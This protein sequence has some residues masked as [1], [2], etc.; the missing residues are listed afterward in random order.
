MQSNDARGHSFLVPRQ[1]GG[2]G[3][4]GGGGGDAAGPLNP[5]L[6][7]IQA[8]G[9]YNDRHAPLRDIKKGDNWFYRGR[10]GYDQATGLGVPDVANLLDSFED[11]EQ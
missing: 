7:F 5:A 11:L 9:G 10:P 8:T 2:G 3:G 6:H 1:W 4:G